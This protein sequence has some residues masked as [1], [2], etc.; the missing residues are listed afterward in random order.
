MPYCVFQIIF[1]GRRAAGV[2]F[3]QGDKNQVIKARKEVIVA[4]G[5]IGSPKLLMLSGVGPRQHLQ[6]LK[7]SPGSSPPRESLKANPS[8]SS[9]LR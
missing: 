8:R 2:L 1:E 7:V 5:T 9:P 3:K 4:A 6:S